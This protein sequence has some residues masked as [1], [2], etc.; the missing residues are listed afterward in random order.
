[1]ALD[2]TQEE[3]RELAILVAP[4]IKSNATDVGTTPFVDSLDGISSLP[5][6]HRVNGITKIVRAAISKLK[7]DKGDDGRALEF[8]IIDSFDTYEELVTAYPEGPERNGF[9]KVGESLYIW[10][11]G[12]Y[13]YLNFDVFRSFAKEQFIEVVPAG[14][15][16]II[17]HTRMPYAKVTLSGDPE[18]FD[19]TINNTKDGSVGKILLSQTGNKRIY[20]T[21]F[22]VIGDVDLP[23]DAGSI[24]LITYNRVGDKI[25]IHSDI[26][27]GGSNPT[28]GKLRNVDQSVDTAPVGSFPVKGEGKW[29]SVAP[30]KSEQTDMTNLL[31]PVWHTTLKA[32]VFVP[33]N[34]FGGA[35]P[36]TPSDTFT[37]STGFWEGGT[38]WG[39]I[40]PLG[41]TKVN[42]GDSL[43]VQ[44][45]SNDGYEVDKVNVDA[46]NQGAITSYT[47]ENVQAD[48]TM[49]AWFKAAEPVAPD[50][51]IPAYIRSDAPLVT[52]RSLYSA[53]ASLV[54]DYP[55]G[56]NKDISITCVSEGID[57]RNN[58]FD[59]KPNNDKLFNSVVRQ[60]N[61][62]TSYILTLDGAGISTID[63]QGFGGI[64]IE[65]SS[66][67]RIRNFI[68]RNCNTYEGVATPEET[69]C[70]YATNITDAYPCRNLYLENLTIIGQST[71]S[72]GSTFRTR[73]G[74]SAKKYDNVYI[75]NCRMNAIACMGIQLSGVKLACIIKTSISGIMHSGIVGHP[76]IIYATGCNEVRIEDCDMNCDSF[77]EAALA[78][79]SI[80]NLY[81]LRN[82]IYNCKGPVLDA[83]G[84]D[85][86]DN[87]VI[88]YNYM[89]DNLIRPLYTWDAQYIAISP[90][91]NNLRITNNLVIF[92]SSMTNEFFFRATVNVENFVN[93]NNI[94]IKRSAGNNFGLFLFN[95]GSIANAVMSN[96]I[97]K[98]TSAL[99]Y[100]FNGLAA[101]SGRDLAK[102]Q[103]LGY[104]SGTE[105]V[106]ISTDILISE[107]GGTRNCLLPT[108]ASA[109]KSVVGY[110]GEFD[111]TYK[112]NTPGNTS[113]GAE[114]YYAED[115]D[116][117]A[118]V[119]AGYTGVD[120]DSEKN[121][122]SVSMYSVPA[123]NVM[124]LHH[125]TKLRTR[126]IKF[127][128]SKTDAPNDK[129]IALGKHALFTVEPKLD[130]NGEYVADQLYN[131]EVE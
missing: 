22:D 9:F 8:I 54:A 82:H 83:S 123:D 114:N 16:I 86:I 32:W 50:D 120:I 108:Y 52:Y 20:F 126:F 41:E 85:N 25:Y 89:H 122:S 131:I 11:N 97:Y 7:G 1:M 51:P 30:V 100:S 101:S 48:H 6:V 46:V 43:T 70:V 49:Y 34:N 99:F 47:F 121:F 2:I 111:I 63:G 113:I 110:V 58:E 59:K 84:I 40:I 73:Y 117:N 72:P 64:Y 60:W 91:C 71:L 79:E 26:V 55:E 62:D 103:E 17:S 88:D 18:V 5:A 44:I 102:L 96:N 42:K 31:V 56:L 28:F 93:A 94:F 75:C 104:E 38:G 109:H 19:I 21:S 4:L 68:F 127:I 14:N 61:R 76:R 90:A 77:N 13:E 107:T 27:L 87:L 67:I 23:T 118:D 125:N 81:M 92:S 24:I 10:V 36:P 33:A 105:L 15:E 106:G 129:V 45:I 112:R 128:I 98:M 124:L 57:Y 95:S 39:T 78:L 12:K 65:D 119:T 130:E 74:I 115:F 66:N 116:E 69:A 80:M 53:I 37:I 35:T 3:L 29:T